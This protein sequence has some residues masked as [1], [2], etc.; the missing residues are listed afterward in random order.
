MAPSVF[1]SFPFDHLVINS[2]LRDFP[3]Q[4]PALDVQLLGCLANPAPIQFKCKADPLFFITLNQ[5]PVIKR[6]H[7]YRW[8]GGAVSPWMG[9]F[10]GNWL[11]MSVAQYPGY[12]GFL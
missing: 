4:R 10:T 8:Q 2:Q 12:A 11:V 5:L 7:F 1:V 3:G 6:A 9:S